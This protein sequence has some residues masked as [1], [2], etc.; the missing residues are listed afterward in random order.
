LAS[1]VS[2]LNLFPGSFG[3]IVVA[4]CLL[5]VTLP[6]FSQRKYYEFNNPEALKLNKKRIELLTSRPWEF[7]QLDVYI[8]DDEHLLP[9][10]GKIDL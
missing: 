5:I 1:L 6:G 7:K 4:P 10:P 9:I 2:I 3:K 8:R